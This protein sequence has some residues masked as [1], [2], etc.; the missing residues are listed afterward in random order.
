LSFHYLSLSLSLSRGYDW[1]S[2]AEGNKADGGDDEGDEEEYVS[3][4]QSAVWSYTPAFSRGNGKRNND[5]E[6]DCFLCI[7]DP[8]R[9]THIH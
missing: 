2:H 9:F 8:Y 3:P 1:S 4:S 7:N 5:D 6:M